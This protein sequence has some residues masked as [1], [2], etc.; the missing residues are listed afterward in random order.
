MSVADVA[1]L[2]AAIVFALLVGLLAVPLL[3]LGK[4]LDATR[5]SIREVTDHTLPV[6]DETAATIASTNAQLGKVDSIT[7]HASEVT[8]NVSALTALFAATVGSPLVKVAAFTYGVRQAF[9]RRKGR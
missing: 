9:G 7:T 4:V 3:K 2:L 6:L 5:D 1:G 8:E